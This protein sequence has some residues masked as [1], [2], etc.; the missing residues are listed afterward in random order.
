[1]FLFAVRDDF[2]RQHLSPRPWLLS[3]ST[4]Q[5]LGGLGACGDRNC[6]EGGKVFV[7]TTTYTSV[8]IYHN[9]GIAQNHF[10]RD[11]PTASLPTL[12]LY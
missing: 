9:V 1:M 3:S 4:I 10:E 8:Y 6:E 7:Y 5:V 11:A 12:L 2:G